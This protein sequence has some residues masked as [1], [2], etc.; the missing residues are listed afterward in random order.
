MCRKLSLTRFQ[1]LD[2]RQPDRPDRGA[3]FAV[4]QPQAAPIGIGFGPP[5]ADHF[6]PTTSCERDLADDI[7]RHRVFLIFAA[8]RNIRPGPILLFGQATVANFILRFANT[9]RRISVDNSGFYGIGKDSAEEANGPRGGPAPPRTIAL[10]R[11]FLVLTPTRVFPAM[12]SFK[13]LLMSALIRSFTRRV[14]R[15]GTIWRLCGQ[16]R[17]RSLRLFR[18]PAFSKIRPAFKSVK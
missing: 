4:D 11:N 5:E 14:P 9:M 6:A 1:K 3:L 17:L 10:P 15:S 8:L 16:C 13:T 7:G 2:N 12:M 18:S